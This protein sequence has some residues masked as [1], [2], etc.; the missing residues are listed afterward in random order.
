MSNN[1]IMLGG[2]VTCQAN[3]PWAPSAWKLWV[4]H[5]LKQ[6]KFDFKKVALLHEDGKMAASNK[7]FLVSKDDILVSSFT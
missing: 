3:M 7:G 6:N 4:D 5:I 1:S 2:L